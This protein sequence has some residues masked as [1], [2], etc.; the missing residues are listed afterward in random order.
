M[1]R[2]NPVIVFTSLMFLLIMF[3]PVLTYAQ[4]AMCVTGLTHSQEGQRMARSFNM[5]I[6]YLLPFPYLIAMTI[7]GIILRAHAQRQG[8][9]L[10]T[11]LK[12]K[13]L[14]HRK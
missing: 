9:T 6:L 4:C 11:W 10:V 7:A 8:M 13:I 5:A 2:S 1:N 3:V 14:Q 12:Y